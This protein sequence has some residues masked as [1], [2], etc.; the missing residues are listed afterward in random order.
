MTF[1][2]ARGWIVLLIGAAKLSL[3]EFMRSMRP[4]KRNYAFSGG[5]F[6]TGGSE[7]GHSGPVESD[8]DFSV[9]CARFGLQPHD[10]LDISANKQHAKC[11]GTRTINAQT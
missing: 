8:L 10:E 2:P 6:S 7:T 5:I 11:G 4:L 3:I 1:C 9:G